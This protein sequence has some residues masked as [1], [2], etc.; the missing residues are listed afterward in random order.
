MELVED[1][2]RRMLFEQKNSHN[3]V[4]N[5]KNRNKVKYNTH[6]ICF[7]YCVIYLELK[8]LVSWLKIGQ[9]QYG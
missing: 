3:V 5:D 9:R 6:I 7:C 2:M 4:L 1:T 8:L